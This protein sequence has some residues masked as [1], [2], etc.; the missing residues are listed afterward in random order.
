MNKIKSTL[1][2]SFIV[3]VAIL[4]AGVIELAAGRP[5]PPQR[6]PPERRQANMLFLRFQD[7]L[8][9]ERWQEVLS[10]CSDRVRASAAKWPAPKDFFKETMPIEAVLEMDFG[11]WSCGTNFYGLFVTLSEPGAEPRIDWHWG[12]VPTEGGWV[13]DFPPVK[14]TEY[15]VKKKAA[16]QERDER[17][18]QIRL[19]LEPKV[20]GV[21]TR[22]TTVSDRFVIGSPMLFQVELLNS[23]PTSV[24]YMD[25]G[26]RHK[27]LTVLNEK[28]EPIPYV[29]QPL[30]IQVGKA[31]LSAGSSVVLAEQIDINKGRQITGPGKYFVQ[32]DSAEVQIGQPVPTEE[33][34]RFGE[35]LTMSVFDFLAAT[36]KFPSNIIQIEVHP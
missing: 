32:F 30:Q 26:V 2:S 8:A 6:H 11:C 20:R 21:K 1:H 28:K 27:S 5:R 35:N 17:I 15:V 24:H 29:P 4:L 12:L 36:N 18:N 25:L 33:M 23:G 7:A 3:L 31:E 22:I 34:G 19:S 13:V 9:A 14:L 10:F 16:F